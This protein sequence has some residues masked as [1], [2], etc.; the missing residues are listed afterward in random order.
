MSNFAI[1]IDEN[2]DMNELQDFLNDVQDETVSYIQEL[3]KELNVSDA[4]AM[5]VWYLRGRSRH[6][7]ELEQE[8]IRLHKAGTTPNI[9]EF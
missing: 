6:T 4:C 7:Q 8:L 1:K 9:M 2:T 3:A 5:D